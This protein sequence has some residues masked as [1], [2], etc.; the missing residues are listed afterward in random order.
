MPRHA[1]P[2]PT[3]MLDIHVIITVVSMLSTFFFKARS[4][5]QKWDLLSKW[6]NLMVV[7]MDNIG[8]E[9]QFLMSF[10]QP[11]PKNSQQ[12]IDKIYLQLK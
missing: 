12:P 11:K 6:E 1:Y 2:N 4:T 3:N 5:N 7:L 8:I 9:D 10:L